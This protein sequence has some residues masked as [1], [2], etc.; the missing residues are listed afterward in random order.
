MMIWLHTIALC[1]LAVLGVILAARIS[2]L[3]DALDQLAGLHKRVE[4]LER[5]RFAKGGWIRDTNPIKETEWL[6]PKM[7]HTDIKE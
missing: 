7:K 2:S 5:N 3:T 6:P 4:Y 1:G